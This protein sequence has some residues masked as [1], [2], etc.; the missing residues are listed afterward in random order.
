MIQF[1]IHTVSFL[2]CHFSL[3]LLAGMRR[4][5]DLVVTPKLLELL[6]LCEGVCF[7][8]KRGNAFRQKSQDKSRL[9]HRSS[10]TSDH[11]NLMNAQ[12]DFLDMSKE[13]DMH[14]KPLSIWCSFLTPSFKT[15]RGKKGFNLLSHVMHSQLRHPSS[16]WTLPISVLCTL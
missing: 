10:H 6:W 4:C 7:I 2:I 15:A 5:F 8:M 11:K 12:T 9:M 16:V 1:E 3:C 14:Y 13:C